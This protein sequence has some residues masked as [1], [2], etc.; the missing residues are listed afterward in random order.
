[1][2][3]YEHVKQFAGRPVVKFNPEKGTAG[4]P[5]G[6]G[7]C[8]VGTNWEGGPGPVQE[9]VHGA[10]GRG[11]GRLGDRALIIAL[12]RKL[13]QR[14]P[15][16]KLAKAADRLTGLQALFLGEMAYEENEISWINQGDVTPL[17]AALPASGGAAGAR[18]RGPGLKPLRHEALRELAFESGGLPGEVVRAVGDCDLPALGHLELWLGTADYG[19]DADVDDLAADPGRRP[20]ARAALSGSARQRDRRRRSPRRSPAPRSSARLETWTCPWAC[21]PTTAPPPCWPA[22]R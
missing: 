14:P 8:R 17:L 21:W 22:S 5:R 1:M 6:G 16:G 15:L 12:G 11:L 2:S 3:I 19:G 4:R 18:R 13:R 10:R 20:A 9:A 7:A